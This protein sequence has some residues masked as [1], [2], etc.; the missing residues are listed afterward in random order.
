MT[1][2]AAARLYEAQHVYAWEGKGLAVYNPH[3]KSVGYLPVIWGFIN[4]NSRLGCEAA[5]L[6]EDGTWL[7]GHL[8]SSPAYASHDLGLLEGSRPDR[9]ET[10]RA[11]Y[12]DGYRMSELIQHADALTHA[13]L[14]AAYARGEA[15]PEESEGEKVAL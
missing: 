1:T 8:C 5:L 10:F 12:P 3:G 11:H 6:A 14:H 2:K 13:G 15:A 4:G 9:H 7:G